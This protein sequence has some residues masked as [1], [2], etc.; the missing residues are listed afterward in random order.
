[1]LWIFPASLVA[2]SISASDLSL[3]ARISDESIKVTNGAFAGLEGSFKLQLALGSE[4]NGSTRV[5]LPTF[6]LQNEAGERLADLSDATPEPMFPIDLNKGE[7]KGVVFTIDGIGVDRAKACAGPVR[8]VGSVMD[9]LK[10]GTQPVRSGA[11]TP[12]CS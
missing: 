4:A 8:I 11:I 10:A 3:S 6:E 1:M 9:T 5:S 7:S 2:C 12:D